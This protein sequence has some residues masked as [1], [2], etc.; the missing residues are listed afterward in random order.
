MSLDFPVQDFIVLGGLPSPG[1]AIIR[2]PNSPRKW[3]IQQGF[4]FSGATL[5]YTGTD[6]A[7]L[8]V[9]IVAWLPEHFAAWE[10]WAKAVLGAPKPVRNPASLSIEHPILSSAPLSI[11]QIVVEDVTG[12]EQVEPGKWIRTIKMIQYRAPKPILVRPFEGPPGDPITVSAPVDPELQ[13]IQANQVQI[14]KLAGP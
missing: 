7:K 2:G 10:I 9:D 8:E 6:L 11:T 3:D 5:V 12:W 1:L 4:G 14:A 13:A